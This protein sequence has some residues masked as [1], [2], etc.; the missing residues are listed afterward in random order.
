VIVFTDDIQSEKLARVLPATQ[1]AHG[2]AARI[3][4]VVRWMRSQERRI[5]LLFALSRC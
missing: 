1:R 3:G 4:R 5:P 2:D